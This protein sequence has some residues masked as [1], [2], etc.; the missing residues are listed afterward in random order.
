MIKQLIK[1]EIYRFFR[2]KCNRRN[3]GIIFLSA[4]GCFAFLV[5]FEKVKVQLVDAQL[6]N[7][8][9]SVSN[10]KSYNLGL[11]K[12]WDTDV[13]T[14]LSVGSVFNALMPSGSIALI[15]GMFSGIYACIYRK[16]TSIYMQTRQIST[17]QIATTFM[18][19]V[20]FLCNFWVAL[21]EL[22]LFVVCAICC[23]LTS[24][25]FVVADGFWV[26]LLLVHIDCTAFALLMSAL[27]VTVKKIL[28]VVAGCIT[29]VLAGG[30]CLDL[31]ITLFGLPNSF[32]KIWVLNNLMDT[33][34]EE[35]NVHCITDT[36]IFASVTSILFLGIIILEFK[37]N[38]KERYR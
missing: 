27:A 12:I 24:M 2:E 18:I 33:S 8:I 7:I 9:G 3:F 5:F 19:T 16:Q 26:W 15:V 23:I 34:I 29:L 31:V 21:Y 1:S 14:L 11:A 4:L 32:R 30:G 37:T 22:I 13:S 28:I 35:V 38:K 6:I 17:R 20:L 36:I 25:E 10:L